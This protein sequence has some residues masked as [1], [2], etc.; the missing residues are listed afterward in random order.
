MNKKAFCRTPRFS[1]AGRSGLRSER[2]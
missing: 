2:D 1:Q